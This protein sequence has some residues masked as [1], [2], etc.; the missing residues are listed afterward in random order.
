MQWQLK[1]VDSE[2][3]GSTVTVEFTAVDLGT[4]IDHF[5]NFLRGCGYH[6]GNNISIVFED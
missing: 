2:P 3:D 4:I 6:I 5:Q 1:R